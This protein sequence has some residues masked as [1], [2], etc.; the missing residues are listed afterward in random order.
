MHS[1]TILQ[2]TCERVHFTRWGTLIGSHHFAEGKDLDWV[3]TMPSGSNTF[4]G[5]SKTVTSLPKMWIHSSAFLHIHPLLPGTETGSRLRAYLRQSRSLGTVKFSD[6]PK[7]TDSIVS[8]G[9]FLIILISG[10]YF[11]LVKLPISSLLM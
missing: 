1:C 8:T 5:K 2:I 9:I 6:V 3:G 7:P 10:K 11:S 4:P